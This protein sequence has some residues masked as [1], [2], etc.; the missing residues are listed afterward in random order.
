MLPSGLM[1]AEPGPE[2]VQASQESDTMGETPKPPG[3]YGDDPGFRLPERFRAE[4]AEIA[5]WPLEDV[6]EDELAELQR[7]FA[8]RAQEGG[9]GTAERL[10]QVEREIHDLRLAVERRARILRE[11]WTAV[12]PGVEHWPVE[13]LRA[14]AVVREVERLL[15]QYLSMRTARDDAPRP[16]ARRDRIRRLRVAAAALMHRLDNADRALGDLALVGFGRDE[17][18]ILR[19]A[20]QGF[21]DAAKAAMW[22]LKKLESRHGKRQLARR[23]LV[24]RLSCVFDYHFTDPA[25]P[26]EDERA[27]AEGTPWRPVDSQ[28]VKPA[29]VV[30]A[31]RAAGIRAPKVDLGH[32]TPAQSRF[33]RDFADD[34]RRCEVCSEAGRKASPEGLRVYRWDA[35][36]AAS[37]PL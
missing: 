34:L 9:P 8:L 1:T 18:S 19:R 23:V 2:G 5:G 31:L 27:R 32:E 36:H 21:D 22:D 4:L 6:D 28:R 26:E 20:L 33:V 13:S 17:L 10:V 15:G 16:S 3:V 12:I 29:F 37:V 14:W 7:L 25:S 11:P 35:P 30:N 24:A